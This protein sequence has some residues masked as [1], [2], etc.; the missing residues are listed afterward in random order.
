[1]GTYPLTVT[2][3]G[4]GTHHTVVVNLTVTAQIA[5]SWTASQ[6]PGTAGYNIYRSTVHGGPYTKANSSVD[7]NTSYNDQAVQDGHTYY[8][9]TTAVDGQGRESGYSNEASAFLP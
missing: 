1:M 7:P 5:L 8:Y 3:T 6:S 4:G 2:A 9:V